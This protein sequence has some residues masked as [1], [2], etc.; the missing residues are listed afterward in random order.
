MTIARPK[1]R[2]A[3]PRTIGLKCA[4]ATYSRDYSH[5]MSRVPRSRQSCD[6]RNS[7]FSM[8]CRG[9]ASSKA[10]GGSKCAYAPHRLPTN[11]PRRQRV[12]SLTQS[13]DITSTKLPPSY[14]IQ[15]LRRGFSN[16]QHGYR[17]I[18][19]PIKAHQRIIRG[20]RKQGP[21]QSIIQRVTTPLATIVTNDWVAC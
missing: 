2:Q 20:I 1:Y 7:S 14:K 9:I 6:S 21:Q 11:I 8:P 19:N 3:F 5:S 12:V 10:Y 4:L 13:R 17:A 15:V 16:W 18:R